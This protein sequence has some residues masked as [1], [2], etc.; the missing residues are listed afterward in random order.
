M[1]KATVAAI[2]PLARRVAEAIDTLRYDVLA[3]LVHP[4]RGLTLQHRIHLSVE[5]LPNLEMPHD[6]QDFSWDGSCPVGETVDAHCPTKPLTPAGFLDQI[7]TRLGPH[8]R[9]STPLT[10]TSE[11]AFGRMLVDEPCNLCSVEGE[12]ARRYPGVPYV[13]YHRRAAFGDGCS[14]EGHQAVIFQFD[15]DDADRW[16]LVGLLRAHGG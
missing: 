14:W 1:S 15:R 11:I 3:F 6:P 7:I 12:L 9:L 4:E 8:G 13:T 5:E 16:W 10:M 2:V